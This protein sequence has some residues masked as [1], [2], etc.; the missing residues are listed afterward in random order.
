M[1]GEYSLI[2]A[3]RKCKETSLRYGTFW[4]VRLL[5]NGMYGLWA[6]S[7]DD[8]KTVACFYNGEDWSNV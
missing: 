8:E 6:H 5:E 3:K 4:Y 7:S 2:V 1:G